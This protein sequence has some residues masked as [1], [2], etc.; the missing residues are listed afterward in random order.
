MVTGFVNE[1]IQIYCHLNPSCMFTVCLYVTYNVQ[2]YRIRYVFKGYLRI[3]QIVHKILLYML[4]YKLLIEKIPPKANKERR[5]VKYTFILNMN[6]A[7]D[8]SVKL[9]IKTWWPK[10][11]RKLNWI[12]NI[13][14][15]FEE[16][17]LWLWIWRAITFIQPRTA[18]GYYPRLSRSMY[19][20]NTCSYSFCS[21][22]QDN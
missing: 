16:Y 19:Q 2:C 9:L 21:W 1:V 20:K 18:V 8:G 3:V 22:P 7:R 5:K 17:A 14:T 4:S 11:Y 6:F 12:P 15:F 10:W 13:H